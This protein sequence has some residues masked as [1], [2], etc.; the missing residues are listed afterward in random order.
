[1]NP[2]LSECAVGINCHS[3]EWEQMYKYITEFENLIGGDYKKYDQ[4]LPSQLIITAFNILIAIARKCNYSAEDILVMET[5]VADVVYAYIAVNGDLISITNGTHISG[6]SLTVIINGICGALN[7]RACFYTHN[8]GA[9]LT[10][11]L[12]IS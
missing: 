11:N 9:Y 5:M 10:A 3:D 7:L 2:L 1:M 4:K 12:S 6:N 8:H